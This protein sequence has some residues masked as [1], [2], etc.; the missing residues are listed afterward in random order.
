MRS[1]GCAV[2]F[3]FVVASGCAATPDIHVAALPPG[4]GTFFTQVGLLAS[5]TGSVYQVDVEDGG[6]AKIGPSSCPWLS[7][8]DLRPDGTVL[9]VGGGV[10]NAYLIDPLMPQSCVELGQLPEVMQAVAVRADG[11][12]FTISD[13]PNHQT[14]YELD[15]ALN[16]IASHPL[17]CPTC[18]ID[19]IDFAPDG[20][21]YAINGQLSW[22][23]LDPATGDVPTGTPTDLGFDFDIDAAGTVR[24]LAGN[25]FKTYNLAGDKLTGV[26][27]G[28][29]LYVEGLVFR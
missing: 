27:I 22:T 3:A 9:G 17:S 6:T 29:T 1:R 16:V 13:K 23:T 20:T 12:V 28:S 4:S 5:E 10:A 18:S 25:Q 7:A 19:G 14:V 8:L 11:H 26:D 2:W 24:A 15:D 21:L